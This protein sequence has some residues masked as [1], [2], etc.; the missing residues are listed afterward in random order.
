[1]LKC[2]LLTGNY[3][4]DLEEVRKL[5]DLGNLYSLS[6]N[7]NPIEAIKGYRMYVLGLMYMKYETLKK[8]DSTVI[9]QNEFDNKVV[10]NERLFS[11]NLD[12]LRRIKPNV[13]TKG[14]PKKE[15]DEHVGK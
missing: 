9:T 2:L 8:L 3:I 12:R 1:M 7:G 11:K 10:W 4:A 13:P 15:E 6:L 5:Q 14:P